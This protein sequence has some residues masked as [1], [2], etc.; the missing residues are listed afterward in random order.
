[1]NRDKNWDNLT[2]ADRQIVQAGSGRSSWLRWALLFV[3]TINSV[4]GCLC[5]SQEPVQR[6]LPRMTTAPVPSEPSA[7][8][9]IA[10]VGDLLTVSVFDA[11]ELSGQFRVAENGEI[12]F[13]LIGALQVNQLSAAQV[14][15]LIK[16]KLIA[17]SFVNDPQVGVLIS[18]FSGQGIS[19]LG[20]VNRPGEYTSA[21]DRRLFDII[22]MAGG[23]A[24]A[25]GDTA[26]V[27]RKSQGEK[28]ASVLIR[29]ARGEIEDTEF[30]LAPGDTVVIKRARIVYVLGDVNR[31]G[32]FVMDHGRL[33]VLRVI[34]LAEGPTKTTALRKVFLIRNPT[35][36]KPA[37]TEINLGKMAKG[38][39]ADIALDADDVLYVP[40]STMRSI[41]L[42][43]LPGVVTSIG[44]AAIYSTLN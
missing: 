25:A 11:P 32:G 18:G 24:I 44:S 7:G 37:I 6:S 8:A 14:G 19:V 5:H 41:I 12:V 31:P 36:D 22:A 3:V 33:S 40:T 29:D 23:L 26:L 20:E 27:Y 34:A 1:M 2:R 35:N 17:E 15:S 21:G 4:I 28:P 43:S 39:I 13:P 10:G 9:D 16:T 30:V 42:S 38:R